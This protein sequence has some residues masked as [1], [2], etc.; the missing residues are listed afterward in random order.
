MLHAALFLIDLC[1]YLPK[2]HPSLPL[3]F[4]VTVHYALE[5]RAQLVRGNSSNQPSFAAFCRKNF[6][7]LN[8]I[9]MISDIR[10]NLTRELAMLGF[11]SPTTTNG[12]G[13]SNNV[14]SYHNRHDNDQALWQA[15]IAAGLY[16][17][18]AFRK[19]GEVN[20]STMTNQKVKVHVSSVNALKGQPLNAKCDVPKGELEFVCF[21][22]MVKGAAQFFTVNQTTHLASP[23]P[24]LLLCGTSLNVRPIRQEGMES[25]GHDKTSNGSSTSLSRQQPNNTKAILTLDG[26]IVFQ[27][28]S[29]VAANI[30]MLRKRLDAAFWH[31]IANPGISKKK[32]KNGSG[33]SNNNNNNNN[34]DGG[35]GKNILAK[36]SSSE[37]DAVEMVGSI[38]QSAHA[39]SRR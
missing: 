3:F 28:D 27:C 4:K 11:P 6:L 9:Q 24:L 1:A 20:F 12:S 39:K 19:K 15:A 21:G 13:R 8:T 38:L 22:E 32:I 23:L 33:S 37:K 35:G 30:V 10:K 7:G 5:A 31:A 16:P 36:L 17:N 25:S 14:Q 18:V 2:C 29:N 34:S 26:W